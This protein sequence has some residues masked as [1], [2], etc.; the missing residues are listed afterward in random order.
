[1]NRRMLRRPMSNAMVG[2]MVGAV[3]VALL[4]LFFILGDLV[5]KGAGS[6]SLDFF[7]QMPAPAGETGGGVAHAI[8]GTL[9]IVGTASLI[10]LPIG[11]AA[12]IYCAEYPGS[13]LTWVTRFVADVLNGTPS[14][15][16][17]VFAWAWIVA[18]QKHFSALAGS[19]ALAMLMIPMV[20]RTTEEMI[21]LVPNSLREAALALG[22]PRWRTS[23]QIVVRTTLARHR[24]RRPARGRPHRRRDGAAALHRPRQPV[25]ELQPQPADGGAA[26]DGLHLRHRPLRGVAPLRLGG[27][28]GPHPG[29]VRPEPRRPTR[30]G[31][32]FTLNG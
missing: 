12:G 24:D 32:R 22:Y 5:V 21:K 6:L 15:V 10:G 16:V 18:T 4:P 28:A 30:D 23:L 27:G 26:A 1:M 7:T 8:V 11:I 2:L 25:H 14:I 17:G 19:A 3:V 29:R 13:R 31:R 9:M 20:L